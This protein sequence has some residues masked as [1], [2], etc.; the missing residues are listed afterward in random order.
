MKRSKAE[1]LQ[2]LVDTRVQDALRVRCAEE[3]ARLKAPATPA[4]MDALRGLLIAQGL[5]PMPNI[6]PPGGEPIGGDKYGRPEPKK[7][8][9]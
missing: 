7:E 2:R 4:E 8:E 6:R 5:L 9:K 3:L 1:R